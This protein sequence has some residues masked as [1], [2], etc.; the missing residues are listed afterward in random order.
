[1]PTYPQHKESGVEWLGKMPAHWEVKPLWALFR[2]KKKT[3]YSEEQLLSVY[4]DFG[5]VL[6]ESRGGNYNRPLDDLGSYQ[7]VQANDLMINKMKAWQ[8]FVAISGYRGIVSP[9]Y[10]VFESKHKENSRFLHYLMRSVKYVAEYLSS[11]KGVRPNQWD[12]K[13]QYHSRM[14]I[15]LPPRTEQTA[16]A[17]FL[18]RETGKI[19]ALVAKQKKLSEL[20]KERRSALI[21]AAVTGKIDVRNALSEKQ[22]A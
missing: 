6:K 18:N 15:L 10:F 11:S 9:A 3:G 5:V 4:R 20:L 14:P 7:L 21:A 1:M 16:I 22:A 8:G 19:D 2:R 12:L 13:P 17:A